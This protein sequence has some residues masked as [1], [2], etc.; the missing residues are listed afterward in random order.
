M[1]YSIGQVSQ[2]TGLSAY[3]LRYYEK[4][5]LLP[6]VQKTPSGIRAYSD[7]DL[8][9]LSLIECL[10]KTGMPIKEIRTYLK[11]YSEGDAT[12][13]N[14]LALFKRRKS[15]IEKELSDLEKILNKVKFKIFLYEE[16]IREK[17]LQKVNH[18]TQIEKLRKELFGDPL[19]FP[20]N[21]ASAK[22]LPDNDSNP[23][24]PT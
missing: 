1:S 20:K 16:A 4:E 23:D 17:S 6:F 18:S 22:N 12:L 2:K 7:E 24:F 8:R 15:I 13:P 14:R 5:G 10:K 21:P 3:T 19:F 9:W 11:W